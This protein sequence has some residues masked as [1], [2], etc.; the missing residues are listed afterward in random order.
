MFLF[1]PNDI[2]EMDIL[3]HQKDRNDDVKVPCCYF[4]RSIL[5]TLIRIFLPR[6]QKILYNLE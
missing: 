2:L 1:V 5:L 6:A 4:I 3:I